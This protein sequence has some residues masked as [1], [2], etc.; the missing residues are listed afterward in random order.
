MSDTDCADCGE[1]IGTDPRSM[2]FGGDAYCGDCTTLVECASCG[3]TGTLPE[4]VL[5]GDAG[6]QCSSCGDVLGGD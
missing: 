3:A 1:S 5:D 2:Q 4:A 6:V